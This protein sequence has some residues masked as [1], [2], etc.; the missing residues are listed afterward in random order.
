[1]KNLDRPDG[2][3]AARRARILAVAERCFFA[4]GFEGCS[5]DAI[6]AEAGM[7]KRD[8]YGCFPSKAALFEAVARNVF[9]QTTRG[10][11]AAPARSLGVRRTLLQ[12]ARSLFEAFA[13]E[14]NLGLFRAIIGTGRH[15]PELAANLQHVR[16]TRSEPVAA[17]FRQLA[18]RGVIETHD[19]ALAA[20]RFGSVAVEGSRYLLGTPL[21]T[22]RER[23]RLAEAAV[24][25]YLSGYLAPS[26]GS[27]SSVAR[28]TP[29]RLAA[30]RLRAGTALRLP[31]AK[32]AALLAAA[33]DQF[34]THGH[35]GVRLDQVAAAAGVGKAT[36]YRHFGDKEGLFRHVVQAQTLA[37]SE[38][39]VRESAAG[40]ELEPVL[41]ALARETLD[42]H[43]RP[44][45]LALQ[46]LMIEEAPA[47][48]ELARRLHDTLVAVTN[49]NLQAVLRAHGRP[50]AG[51]HAARAFHTLATL[52]TRLVALSEAPKV[53][54]RDS[55]SR[56]TARIFLRGAAAPGEP[57]THL[58]P[59]RSRVVRKPRAAL[60]R[61]AAEH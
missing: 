31:P 39:P 51:E 5:V 9:G 42:R 21:P 40:G 15:F 23:M 58:E 12:F 50:S 36:L 13:D 55:L 19:P 2:A 30:P 53:T 56:E 7:S 59:V 28:V 6:A 3:D 32:F 33:L 8:L 29:L 35:R 45:S 18:E 52:G 17:Y 25:F 54:D 61:A 16:T 46:R 49:R 1:M 48:P 38:T 43:V 41:A 37:I 44:E 10:T 4:Q 11:I 22:P 26:A 14:G 24:D 57:R 47:F 20:I 60:R 34:L 27:G